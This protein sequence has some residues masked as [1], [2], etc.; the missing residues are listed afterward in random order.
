[1]NLEVAITTSNVPSP[2]AKPETQLGSG[3][4]LVSICGLSLGMIEGKVDAILLDKP[5]LSE[6]FKLRILLNPSS[7][8]CN[9]VRIISTIDLNS[10]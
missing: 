1:M 8:R 3:M 5:Q 10:I 6:A 7:V 2:E 9:L 4:V